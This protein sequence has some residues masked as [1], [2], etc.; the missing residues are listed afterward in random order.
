VRF[1]V[2]VQSLVSVLSTT[3]GVDVG[4]T[5][6]L[7]LAVQNQTNPARRFLTVPWTLA[8]EHAADEGWVVSAA[9]NVVAKLGVDATT[10]AV[11]VAIDP[12]DPTRVLELPTGKNPRGIVVN[13][14][15]TRAFVMNYVSRDV[16]VID[17]TSSPE[18]VRRRVVVEKLPKAKT[19]EA[20][21]HLGKEL[22]NTSIGGPFAKSSKKHP[23]VGRMSKDGWGACAACHPFGL[24]D[25]VVWIFASGP[26][27]TIPQHT[28]FDQTD[29]TR[30]KQ[31][32]LNWSAIF[33]EQTDFEVYVRDV[34]GGD[35]LLVQDDGFT[36]EPD[37][38]AL[39][40]IANT[41]RPQ[42]AVKKAKAWEAIAA[43]VK[44]GIRAPLSPVA[45]TEPDVIAG[46][47]LF[48]AANCQ[49]CHG[50][51]QW[52][53]S[54]VRYVPPAS[55]AM[56]SNGQLL[57]ELRNV[58]TFDPFAFNEVRANGSPPLGASGFAPASLL[59]IG[60]F[61]QTFFHNGAAT[62]LIVVM[63]AVAHRSAGTGGVDTLS[64]AADRAK[65]VRFLESIDAATAPL[66]GS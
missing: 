13:A 20:Q 64:N 21:I 51:A 31:R 52:T 29:P 41:G 35:G 60:A 1:D 37:V 19:P 18:R 56:V 53:S 65:V 34:S 5:V 36:P 45:K 10:G 8:F 6:N 59:S 58:G 25:D 62:S 57:G 14:A 15:D 4:R 55:A 44:F 49:Q 63:Q 30:A 50:G 43:Y 3:T 26:R 46:R 7:N 24:S 40:P 66:P 54:R 12:G 32:A 42:L 16:T 17:L 11:T 39:T 48:T 23:L 27:R 9:S 22:Y 47:A 28:D 38:P 33:D 2:N 61:P